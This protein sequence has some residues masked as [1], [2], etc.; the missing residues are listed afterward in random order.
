M[1]D[2]I[3]K[4]PSTHRNPSI[5]YHLLNGEAVDG[6]SIEHALDE[7]LGILRHVFPLWIRKVILTRS[8]PC[9]HARGNCEPMITVEGRVAA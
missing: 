5:L 2:K 4:V 9:L 7:V 6:I 8:Y 3:L 1:N